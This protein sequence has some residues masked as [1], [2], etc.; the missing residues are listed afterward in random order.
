[1]AT[2]EK[3]I[4]QQGGFKGVLLQVVVTGHCE[5]FLFILVLLLS[6]GRKDTTAH[7]RGPEASN[8]QTWD[9]GRLLWLFPTAV[10]NLSCFGRSD[11]PTEGGRNGF[12]TV[13]I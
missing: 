2:G 3:E 8:A 4:T 10:L 5:E 11:G 13:L 9:L 1:M 6:Q 7:I 12:L